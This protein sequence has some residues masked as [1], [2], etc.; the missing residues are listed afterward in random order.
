MKKIVLAVIGF[1]LVAVPAAYWAFGLVPADPWPVH[2]Y[3]LGRL[4]TLVAFVLL[5]FQYVLSARVKWIERCSISP[6]RPWR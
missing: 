4:C 3:D 6:R 5:F 1:L 2:L